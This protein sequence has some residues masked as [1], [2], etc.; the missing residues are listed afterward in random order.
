MLLM[1]F[2]VLIPLS[3]VRFPSFLTGFPTR[4]V[5]TAIRFLSSSFSSRFPSGF[6]L[7]AER[8]R[9]LLITTCNEP[10]F[11]FFSSYSSLYDNFSEDRGWTGRRTSRSISNHHRS[12]QNCHVS[13]GRISP[14]PYVKYSPRHIFRFQVKY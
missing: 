1:G 11:V 13:R 4:L 9:S 7:N 10:T 8:R 2:P 3:S 12:R 6:A 14:W 5:P